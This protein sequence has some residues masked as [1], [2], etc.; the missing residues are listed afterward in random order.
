LETGPVQRFQMTREFREFVSGAAVM[1][2]V[3]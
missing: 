2:V 3:G 1:G